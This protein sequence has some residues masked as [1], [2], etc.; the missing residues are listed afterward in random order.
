[1]A[2]M[3]VKLWG[4]AYITNIYI[5]VNVYKEIW[6]HTEVYPEQG[7]DTGRE[8]TGRMSLALPF[9]FSSSV[10]FTMAYF[11]LLEEII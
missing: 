10:L 4:E 8:R 5:L 7:R 1:M 11:Y 2:S 3:I 6:K 9:H